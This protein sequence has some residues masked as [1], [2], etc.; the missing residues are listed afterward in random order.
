MEN[1]VDLLQ[2]KIDK[3]REEL[4]EESRQAIDAMD[5]KNIIINMRVE[6]RL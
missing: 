1:T 4:P 6:E 2:I 3:A 5:W